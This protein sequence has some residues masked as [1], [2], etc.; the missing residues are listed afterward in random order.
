MTAK[1][2]RKLS[3]LELLEM[4]LQQVEENE[5][6]R[7]E[8]DDIK[9]KLNERT[10]VGETSGSIAEAALQITGIFDQA[11]HAADCYLESIRMANAEPE[12]YVRK[13][14]EDAQMQADKIIAE[15]ERRSAR[16]RQEADEY[17]IHMRQKVQGILENK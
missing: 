14:Q 6:L 2:L 4:L 10:V 16:I 9:S 12:A 3:R 5:I 7:R 8:L 1:E 15:A 17:W 11:Q 13:I